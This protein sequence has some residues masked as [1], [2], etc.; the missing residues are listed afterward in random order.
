MSRSPIEMM[1]TPDEL[2]H[3]IPGEMV[4]IIQLPRR[5]ANDRQAVLVEQVLRRL[6]TLLARYDLALEAYGTA[7]RWNDIPTMPPVRRRS[8]IFGLH[9][10]QP[11]AALFFHVLHADAQ[12]LDPMPMAVSYLHANL[13]Q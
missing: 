3:W 8:F 13:E 11:Y 12:V 9:K 1:G 10:Q 5:L 4:V 6:N 2:C 7:G